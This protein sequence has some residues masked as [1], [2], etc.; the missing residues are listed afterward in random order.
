MAQACVNELLLEISDSAIMLPCKVS[1]CTC[2]LL[3]I[4]IYVCAVLTAVLG[5]L[6]LVLLSRNALPFVVVLIVVSTSCTKI[7]L[8]IWTRPLS[9]VSRIHVSPGILDGHE[10]FCQQ[11]CACTSQQ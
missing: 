5:L 11:S 7:F 4:I 10:L 3:S 2:V 1:S 9:T 6:L 8:A